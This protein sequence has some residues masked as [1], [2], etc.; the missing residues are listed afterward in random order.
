MASAPGRIVFAGRQDDIENYYA[1]ANLSD[2]L[3]AL[4]RRAGAPAPS[5]AARKIAED[6]FWTRHFTRL[7]ALR[8]RAS[9][10]VQVCVS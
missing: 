2:Q 5:Q 3:A 10:R 7:D 6:Y 9:R 8:Q 4:L 1:A